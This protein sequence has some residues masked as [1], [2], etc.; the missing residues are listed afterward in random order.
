MRRPTPPTSFRSVGFRSVAACI[1]ASA[2]VLGAAE[3]AAARQSAYATLCGAGAHTETET[4]WTWLPQGKLFCPLAADPK[5]SRS[6]ASY[7]RGDFSSLADPSPTGTN[8]ASVG[9]G[10]SFA[11]LR[12]PGL[13]PGNGIQVDIEGAV[14]SQFN[15]DRESL[16]LVN[17][18]YLV[19]LPITM[20]VDGFT[21]RLR[22]YHQSSHLG[23]EFLLGS[24]FEDR[25]NL[26]FESA[27][28]IVSQEIGRFRLY[29]GGEAFFRREPAE[30]V[31]RIVHAGAEI[32]PVVFGNGRVFGAVDV[33][34]A[35]DQGWD[36]AV[37]AKAGIEIARVPTPGHP[38]EVITI[39]FEYYDG[40]AP[41]G[42]FYLESIRFWGVSLQLFG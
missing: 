13:R 38:A 8:L 42:Q 34:A 24:T 14:F 27:E 21:T 33:K 28:V 16:D 41:Y 25:V 4:G 26:S 5:A 3:D 9:L 17:A 36:R 23:D 11:L 15:L 10:D 30:L 19:G 40:L 39:S 7:L 12:L 20:R 18:D 6:F 32:R 31:D 1:L 35:P 22:V 29:G 37:S 2:L